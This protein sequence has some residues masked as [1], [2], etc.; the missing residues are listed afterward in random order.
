MQS[1]IGNNVKAFDCVHGCHILIPY[2]SNHILRQ[3]WLSLQQIKIMLVAKDM[4]L[5][6]DKGVQFN[7]SSMYHSLIFNDSYPSFSWNQR[8]WLKHN[9]ERENLTLWKVINNAIHTKQ[10]YLLKVLLFQLPAAFVIM[11]LKATFIF[12]NASSSTHYGLSSCQN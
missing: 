2:T 1:G 10:I 5:W 9:N 8:V 4:A 12:F 3:L 6:S 7:I 11:L